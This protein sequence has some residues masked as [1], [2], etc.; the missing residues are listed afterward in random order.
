MR[1]RT[2]YMLCHDAK[3]RHAKH[4]H[5]YHHMGCMRRRLS[6][7][8]A[9]YASPY[10]LLCVTAMCTYLSAQHWLSSRRVSSS[11]GQ[12]GNHLMM[13]RACSLIIFVT[14]RQLVLSTVLNTASSHDSS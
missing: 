9:A 4:A 5:V 8:V 3:R 12:D 11:A 6:A 7:C 2:G 14:E 10:L 13:R 1:R